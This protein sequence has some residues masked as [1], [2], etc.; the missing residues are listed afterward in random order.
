MLRQTMLRS[1]FVLATLIICLVL[2]VFPAGAT[3]P[4]QSLTGP[5]SGARLLSSSESGLV[6]DVRVPWQQLRLEPAGR[7]VHA[8]LPGWPATTEPGAPQLPQ[9]TESIGAPLGAQVRVR[10]RPGR[11]HTLSLAAPVS[12][13]PTVRAEW[14][15]DDPEGAPA[16]PQPTWI[17]EEDPTVYGARAPYPAAL[18]QPGGDGVMRQQRVV[19]I[20][21]SPVQYYPATREL[22]IYESLRIEVTFE[23]VPAALGQTRAS[24]ESAAYESLFQQELLN[25]EAARAWRRD[26]ARASVQDIPWAP[27]SP[28][29]RV[30]V[31]DEGM[32]KLTYADLLAND[33]PV[34]SGLSTSTF[35]LFYR[36]SEVPLDVLDRNGNGILESNDALVF[37]GQAV[38]SKYTRYNVYW[39]THGQATG[40]RMV[41]RDATPTGLPTPDYHVARYHAERNAYYIPKAPGGDDLERWLW[42]SV[43]PPSRPTWTTPMTLTVPYTAEYSPTLT[44]SML[45]YL[46][47]AANPDHHVRI[48]LNGHE[49]AN[50][51][52]DGITWKTVTRTFPAAWL[53]P[54][55]NDLTFFDPNDLGVSSDIVYIDEAELEYANTFVAADNNLSFPYQSAEGKKFVVQ[56]LTLDPADPNDRVAVYDVTNPAAAVSLSGVA[57][58]ASGSTYNAE[59]ADQ[60]LNSTRY[61]TTTLGGM[62]EP[63]AIE[64]DTPSNL[65]AT[66]NGADHIIITHPDLAA[67]ATRLRNH[68]ASQMRARLVDIQDIYDEFGY[69]IA[70]ASAIRGFLAYTYAQWQ[71]PSPSFVVLF[72]DGHYD[73][74]DYGHYGT[75]S[76][77]PPLLA[78]ADP[79]IVETA[80]DN[81]YVT[82]AGDDTVPDMMLGR[83]AVNDNT[84]AQALV[85]KII[86]YELTPISGDWRQQVLAVADN[87]D[88]AGNFAQL[89]DDLINGYLPAPNQAQKVYLGVTHASATEAKTAILN[90]INAGK[91][92]VNY[93]GHAATWQW[94]D[95]NLFS[96]TDVESLANDKHPV[97]LP[98]TCYDGYYHY[99]FPPAANPADNYDA[100]AEVITRAQGKGAVASWAPTGLGVSTGHDLLD[101]GFFEAVYGDEDG[102]ITLGEATMAGKL[103]L[104]STIHNPSHTSL[105]LLDTYLLFGDPATYVSVSN[106]TATQIVAFTATGE[107][108]GITLAWET[109]SEPDIAGFN[110]YRATA[111]D[112]QKSKVNTEIIPSKVEPGSPFGARYTYEDE[113]AKIGVRYTYWLS[114][115]SIYGQT[116][117]HGPVSAQRS[118]GWQQRLPLIVRGRYP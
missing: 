85:D 38:A 67:Q 79:W 66:T 2:L 16:L 40:L 91:L 58:V 6:F 47:Y 8:S 42:Y 57:Q 89:S 103:K 61:W 31:E 60:P 43:R 99:P 55:P 115:S 105:D 25:Y 22:T 56:G 5:E 7:Y 44:V 45:G 90:A 19:G 33:V 24:E 76:F 77:I 83:L 112:G 118:G 111:I 18:A 10:V 80:A 27:P 51:T 75:R 97:M 81:R 37:F 1:V 23:G 59:F 36:G 110:V 20:V 71:P 70:D 108:E 69:G 26:L 35:Q 46:Q 86:N 84:Q 92:I 117:E 114:V 95:E 32:Y 29:W 9:W 50:V 48:S 62:R 106:P 4:A 78:A 52:W 104:A 41:S 88:L 12:P 109:A 93:I 82:L 102:Q 72:G 101:T 13:V 39:L 100:T 53:R 74:K 15:A 11:A 96:A 65:R 3:Q 49:V 113:T 28:G 116:D 87:Q 54:G 21:T 73:P 63:Q 107:E 30:L 98:M 64:Q 34:D 68:R 94:A 14:S 17:F